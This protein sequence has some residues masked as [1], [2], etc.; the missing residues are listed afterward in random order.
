M[1]QLCVPCGV[2]IPQVRAAYK[3]A[4]VLRDSIN[5]YLLRRLKADVKIQLPDKNEQ[6]LFCRL[7]EYQRELYQ[8]FIHSPQVQAML[9]GGRQVELCKSPP[10]TL[11]VVMATIPSHNKVFSGLVTLRKLCNHPDL[12]TGDYSP[13]AAAGNDEDCEDFITIDVPKERK[14]QCMYTS[15]CVCV[16]EGDGVA[17][18]GCWNI[19]TTH[20]HCSR[21]RG[22]WPLGQGRENDCCGVT[23]EALEVTESQSSAVHSRQAG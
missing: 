1:L 17:G 16:W 15:V 13:T 22:L 23:F 21:G 11:A 3:C 12:V 19:P 20:H 14:E 10:P 7:T 9:A 6:V 5:P 18:G 2:S 8:D 4:C